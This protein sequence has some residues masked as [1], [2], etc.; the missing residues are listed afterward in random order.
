MH[1]SVDKESKEV[2]VMRVTEEHLHDSRKLVPPAK[3][4][5]QNCN[6]SRVKADVADDSRNNFRFLSDNNIEPDI[7]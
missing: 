1:I 6:V 7:R 5:M 3:R 2:V 4:A